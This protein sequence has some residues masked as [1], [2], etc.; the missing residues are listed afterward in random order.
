M[1]FTYKDMTFCT[2]KDCKKTCPR[3]LTDEIKNKAIN[4]GEW[5]AMANFNCEDKDENNV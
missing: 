2:T 4:R 5:L 1:M 3:R